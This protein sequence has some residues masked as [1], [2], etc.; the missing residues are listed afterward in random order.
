MGLSHTEIYDQFC[1]AFF[2]KRLK[3][4]PASDSWEYEGRGITQS[5]LGRIV[6]FELD[7]ANFKVNNM[8]SK[9]V[10]D[11]RRAAEIRLKAW[12]TNVENKTTDD[13]E[14]R[15]WL[16]L[17]ERPDTTGMC[18]E[19]NVQ[20]MKQWLWQVKRGILERSVVWHVAPIFWSSENGTGKSFN[21]RRIIAPV[22]AFTRNVDV[23]ELG[24]KFSGRLFAQTLVAFL[25]EFAGVENTDTAQL[26]AILTGKPIDR[27]SM[28]S[29][30]GFYSTNRMSC[31]ATSNLSPPHGFIDHTGAR[32]FWSI[33][34]N[35]ESMKKGSPR[36][37]AFDAIDVDA[38]WAAISVG[39]ASPH[40]TAH[41]EITAY[42]ERVRTE[43]LRTKTSLE[44]FC[45]ECL[46]YSA[47]DRVTLKDFQATYKNYCTA[48]R[49]VTVRSSYRAIS[50]VLRAL[51][52]PVVNSNNRYYLK[53]HV[54]VDFEQQLID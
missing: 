24:E 4:R 13:R 1:K 49:Q 34:C 6:S 32:R 14:L 3:F 11:E 36:M 38:V 2:P 15:R 10:M 16:K 44:M 23:N 42:M 40:D 9:A 20:A 37:E 35:G 41:P 48:F 25:D 18:H 50:D 54:F 5:E 28:H 33:H 26:K 30:S 45:D 7:V 31:L 19:A 51:G 12:L 47:N 52:Y 43:R 39:E 46:E 8:L 17:M 29:E 21:I 27:R 53:D 22:D